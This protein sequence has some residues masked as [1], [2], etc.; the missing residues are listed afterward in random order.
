MKRLLTAS[1]SFFAVCVVASFILV[2]CKTP[3]LEPGGAYAPTNVVGQ[4]V[5]NDIGLA[6]VDA[7]YKFAYE[8]IQTVFKFE[9][10][11]RPAIWAVSHNVKKGLDDARPRVVEWDKRWATARFEYRQ[12]PTPAGLNKLQTI[13]AEMNR[14]LPI[15]QSQLTPAVTKA[16]TP[17]R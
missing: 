12:N 3:S 5:S 16:A 15:V 4:V 1:I 2:G 13:L 11:N 7:S 14:L 6:L 10:D 8:S 9:R 17:T